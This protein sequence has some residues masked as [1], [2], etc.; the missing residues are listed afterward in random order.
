M[1]RAHPRRRR[2]PDR[3]IIVTGGDIPRA[4]ATRL[5]GMGILLEAAGARESTAGLEGIAVSTGQLIVFMSADLEVV[6]P[7]WLEHCLF[8]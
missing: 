5:Q 2:V 7:E 1:C 3:Q 4:E 8:V 6:T